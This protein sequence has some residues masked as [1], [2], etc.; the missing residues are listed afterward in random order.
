MDNRV[1][2]FNRERF[3]HVLLSFAGRYAT[4]KRRA[5]V[6]GISQSSMSRLDNMSRLPTL[7]ELVTICNSSGYSPAD[8]FEVI[9]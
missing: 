7:D 3:Q 4:Q 8:F 9:D 6:L 5:E 1:Y 2:T